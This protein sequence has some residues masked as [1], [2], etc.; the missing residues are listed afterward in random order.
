MLVACSVALDQLGSYRHHN[1]PKLPAKPSILGTEKL[2]PEPEAVPLEKGDSGPRGAHSPA[3]QQLLPRHAGHE[4]PSC[5]LPAGLFPAPPRLCGSG[6][7]AQCNW[8]RA[9]H[10]RDP[11]AC[12]VLRLPQHPP[13]PSAPTPPAAAL[14]PAPQRPLAFALP[15]PPHLAAGASPP[16]IAARH[17]RVETGGSLVASTAFVARHRGRGVG[18]RFCVGLRMSPTELRGSAAG[19]A[20]C[21]GA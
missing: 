15:T 21:G 2:P 18:S 13:P 9:T 7:D 11:P 20:G 6:C 16:A 17:R 10:G 19:G 4:L 12:S 8:A 1:L 5:S 3:E 14:R